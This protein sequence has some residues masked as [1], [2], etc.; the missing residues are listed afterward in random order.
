VLLLDIGV[1]LV[2]YES[3]M[4]IRFVWVMLLYNN[5]DGS[6]VK[7]ALL[8]TLS[9]VK[10]AITLAACFSIPLV[11]TLA[12]GTE[13]PFF[14]RDLILFISG[15]VIIVSI[16]VASVILPV[17]FPKEA[18]KKEDM[19]LTTRGKL[20]KS[21]V[22]QISSYTS[23]DNKHAAN[24]L[25]MYYEGLMHKRST[26]PAA[27]DIR[28]IKRNE[29]AIFKIGLTVERDELSRLISL[30]NSGFDAEALRS[31]RQTIEYKLARLENRLFFES[32]YLH[33]RLIYDKM[34]NVDNDELVR[35]KMYTT[36]V[37]VREINKLE[38]SKNVSACRAAAAHFRYKLDTFLSMHHCETSG[39][40]NRDIRELAHKAR[41]AE[42][43][44][45]NSLYRRGEIDNATR[46]RLMLDIELEEVAQLENEADG[47]N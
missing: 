3:I 6:R 47:E 17:I 30:G 46:V 13:A 27:G 36:D 22:A 40:Y 29:M 43:S 2:I 8:I 34:G 24:F 32:A 5:E 28:F 19:E 37:A 1:V 42:K 38:T 20:L 16:L 14:E 23:E 44:L 9:G 7:N 31:I 12:D 41:Q 26:E 11:M 39:K 21:A 4:L 33:M 10:G 45:L 35:V 18:G 15:G 25:L